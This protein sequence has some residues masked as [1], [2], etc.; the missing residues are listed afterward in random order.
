MNNVIS[1]KNGNYATDKEVALIELL[2]NGATRRE[3]AEKLGISVRTVEGRLDRLRAKMGCK[4]S[5][6]LV[7]LFVRCQTVDYPT[8]SRQTEQ[9]QVTPP[10]SSSLTILCGNDSQPIDMT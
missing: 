3:A 6:E 7:A 2:A 9:H 8:L 4:T 1:R 5:Y 10:G